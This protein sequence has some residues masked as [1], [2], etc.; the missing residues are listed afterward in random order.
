MKQIFLLSACVL[1]WVISGCV[2]PE[3]DSRA[4]YDVIDPSSQPTKLSTHLGIA[5]ANF[6]GDAPRPNSSA[7]VITDYQNQATVSNNSIL[8]LPF[9]FSGGI[10]VE[11]VYLQVEGSA[12]Y[13]KVPLDDGT[14]SGQI[15]SIL[16]P[17]N[18][19]PGDFQISYCLYWGSE[20]S[21][22]RELKVLVN[23]VEDYCDLGQLPPAV[24]GNDGIHVG[25]YD[26]GGESGTAYVYFDTYSVP[27]RVDIR[28]AGEWIY[29]SA[30]ETLEE[31]ALPAAKRC[32][33]VVPGDGYRGH[34]KTIS[35]EYDPTVGRQVEVYM[36][37][38]LDGGT[39]WEYQVY[40]PSAGGGGLPT[41]SNWYRSLP[42][43]PCSY[44]DAVARGATTEPAG[45]WVDCGKPASLEIYHYG[46]SFEVRWL[47]DE[48]G[49]AGQQCTYD[50][51]GQLISAGIAAGTPD[52]SSPNLCGVD[53]LLDLREPN[54]FAHKR[55]DIRPWNTISCQDYLEHWPPNE[56]ECNAYNA[57]TDIDDLSQVVG[58]MTC[59]D[60]IE[61]IKL[62]L[63]DD[64]QVIPQEIKDYFNGDRSSAPSNLKETLILLHQKYTTQALEVSLLEIPFS[65]KSE[66]L[67]KAIRNLE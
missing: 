64:F 48:F 30:N 59:P 1:C 41:S 36:F 50:S 38:C 67:A 34:S 4:P 53:G 52:K 65:P 58:T 57:V 17:S 46:A 3:A 25:S 9:I 54:Y 8:F 5:G 35:F 63:A 39:A 16:I 21:E 13:W 11:G 49:A 47:P 44:S 29:T 61:L 26:L 45:E 31:N 18:V 6:E 51:D 2:K 22:S 43:C 15:V 55:D 28:Y 33:Q 66:L 24:R 42:D 10:E 23:Q 40:C 27:D 62:I 19:L 7:V 60:I 37:G 14:Q 32:S 20:V 56:G 12:N